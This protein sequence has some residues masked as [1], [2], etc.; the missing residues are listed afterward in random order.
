MW[1]ECGHEAGL[2]KGIKHGLINL[3]TF[4]PDEYDYYDHPQHGDMHVMVP[5]KFIAF[6]GRGDRREKRQGVG[7]LVKRVRVEG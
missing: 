6:K 7:C 4:N 1:H 2:L 5:N 3:S